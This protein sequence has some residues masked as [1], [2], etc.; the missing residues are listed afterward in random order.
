VDM[1]SFMETPRL[2]PQKSSFQLLFV[3]T[4]PV[5]EDHLR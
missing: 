3:L 2:H 5:L 4:I 1:S